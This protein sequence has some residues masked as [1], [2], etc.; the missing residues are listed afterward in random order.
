MYR[1]ATG[2]GNGC[3]EHHPCIGRDT[4]SREVPAIASEERG[5]WTRTLLSYDVWYGDY[6]GRANVDLRM[7]RRG[8]VSV[9]LAG[10]YVDGAH[11]AINDFE[12]ILRSICIR[13][14]A[15]GE[16]CPI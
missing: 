8:D 1:A 2:Q 4:S 12:S 11:G 14:N 3:P 9:L 15:T 6:G 10:M 16:C 13:P 5:D 7:L